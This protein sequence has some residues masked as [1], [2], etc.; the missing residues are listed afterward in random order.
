MNTTDTYWDVDGASLQTYAHNITSWGGDRQAP[1]MLRG[2]NITVPSRAGTVWTPK[3]AGSR[4][5]SLAMWV[6]G[7]NPD[8]SMPTSGP[9]RAVFEANW[10]KLRKLLW[11]PKRQITLTKR[12]YLFGDN[13]L[14]TASAKAQYSGGLVPTMQGTSAATFIVDLDLSFPYFIG[15]EE[16]FSLVGADTETLDVLGDDRTQLITVDFTGPINTPR[17]TA[18]TPQAVSWMQ[19]NAALVT[20][21]AVHVDVDEWS[22]LTNPNVGADFKSSGYISRASTGAS[23]LFLDPGT[24][25]VAQTAVSGTG[26]TTVKYRPVWL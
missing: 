22:S 7:A 23:W 2:S 14:F 1:P 5:M 18:T 11:T 3:V 17:V 24:N 20:G 13:T 8:G 10:A 6:N 25:I 26:T 12:F 4:S 15:E 21:D 19:Y 16:T 9:Q